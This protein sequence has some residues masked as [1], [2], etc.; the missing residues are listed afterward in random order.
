MELFPIQLLFV[1]VL[2]NRYILG[3]FLRRMKG[4]RFDAVDDTFC[5]T[6]AV[7][8][9]L[10]NEGEGI[11]HAVRSLV[12]QDYPAEKLEIIVVDDC[13]TDDS[14]AWALKAG[15]GHPNVRVMRNP[16]NM[17][18]RK[19]INR[20]VRS[21]QAE[22]VISVDSD[23]IADQRAVKELVRRFIHPKV[24]AV[25]G[26]TYVKNRHENWLTR[27]IE[28]KFYFAQE[29]LKDLERGFQQVMCLSGCLTAYRRHVLEE[30]EPILEARSIAGVPIKYGEDR[31]LTRQIIKA[32]Y[33]TIYTTEAWCETAAPANLAGYFS[34]QL[35]WRRSNLVD[36]LGGLSHAW[37]LHPVI[38]IHYVSQFVLMLTYPIVIIHNTLN[39]GFLDILTFHLVVVGLLGFIYRVETRHLPPERRVAGAWF[40]PMA[41]MMPVTYTLFTPLALLT[42]DSGSWETRGSP[43]PAP[44]T[45]SRTAPPSAPPPLPPPV[46]PPAPRPPQLGQGSLP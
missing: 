22:I 46:P 11:Y 23:V 6:V 34:Q 16:H 8:V 21:T 1:V 33:M 28:I 5:P 26:R 35:R 3:P 45:D 40:L 20:G 42:L 41:L 27:M 10:F 15:E 7:V 2:M 19:G 39:G 44:A 38:T 12:A 31:F 25:G 17:G 30:L 43:A 4:A 9:P 32:G 13:S 36:M 14:M 29:W 18:K 24:A 37:R